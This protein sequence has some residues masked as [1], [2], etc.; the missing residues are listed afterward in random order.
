METF[1]RKHTLPKL[2]QYK[3]GIFEGVPKWIQMN[4]EGCVSTYH[5]VFKQHPLEDVSMYVHSTST[6]TKP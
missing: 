4:D 3:N 1:E 5:L 2:G 6:T